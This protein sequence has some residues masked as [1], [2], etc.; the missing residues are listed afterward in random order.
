MDS[1]PK[2]NKIQNHQVEDR[3]EEK[4]I[5]AGRCSQRYKRRTVVQI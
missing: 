5:F 3:E 2:L 1:I 4:L